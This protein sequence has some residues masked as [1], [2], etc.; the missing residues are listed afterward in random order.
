MKVMDKQHEILY[1]IKKEAEDQEEEDVRKKSNLVLFLYSFYFVATK[2]KVTVYTGNKI[3][4]GTD[5]DV[6]ITLYG[7][8]GESG[9]IV[10]DDKKNNFEA[11]K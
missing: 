6:F 3:G 5:A 1:Y 4:A 9:A 8:F 11:G 10:L 7:N 2:Y